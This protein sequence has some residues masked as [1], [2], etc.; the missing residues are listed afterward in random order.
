MHISKV[1]AGRRQTDGTQAHPT[2]FSINISAT[3]RGSVLVAVPDSFSGAIT[4]ACSLSGHIRDEAVCLVADAKK[5][6]WTV[7]QGEDV[8]A[9]TQASAVKSQYPP[10]SQNNTLLD[11]AEDQTLPASNDSDHSSVSFAL[12]ELPGLGDASGKKQR[13]R[14]HV[15]YEADYSLGLEKLNG[16]ESDTRKRTRNFLLFYAAACFSYIT[17]VIMMVKIFDGPE[18]A[19]W[20]FILFPLAMSLIVPAILAGENWSEYYYKP[21]PVGGIS[22]V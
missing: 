18:E 13:E 6:R 9:S 4:G 14:R 2:P 1:D 12:I 19:M 17:F 15:V 7:R 21:P 3:S 10:S 5:S 22:A 20:A 16:V 11:T 8:Y